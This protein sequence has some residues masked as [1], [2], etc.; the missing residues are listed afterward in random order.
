MTKIKS[1]FPFNFKGDITSV[2]AYAEKMC[3]FLLRNAKKQYE[4]KRIVKN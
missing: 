4:W 1:F 2:W 3:L